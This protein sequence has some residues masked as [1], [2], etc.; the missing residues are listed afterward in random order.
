[1]IARGTEHVGDN[2]EVPDSGQHLDWVSLRGT[3]RA[4]AGELPSGEKVSIKR[5]KVM[6]AVD[7]VSHKPCSHITLP[8]VESIAGGVDVIARLKPSRTGKLSVNREVIRGYV[9][10]ASTFAGRRAVRHLLNNVVLEEVVTGGSPRYAITLR[11]MRNV[12]VK[13][14]VLDGIV[15]R[16]LNINVIARG[17]EGGYSADPAAVTTENRYVCIG[18]KGIIVGYE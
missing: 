3:G 18:H 10:L 5:L 12:L 7:I 2:I 9:T 14:A 15:R 6:S 16:A 4:I 1:V 11:G 17:I 8:H 13:V